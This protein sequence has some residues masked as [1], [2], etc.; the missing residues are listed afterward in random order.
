VLPVTAARSNTQLAWTALARHMGITRTARQRALIR[1]ALRDMEW[2][3][4]V[5]AVLDRLDGRSEAASTILAAANSDPSE[6][7]QMVGIT[8]LSDRGQLIGLQYAS[9]YRS[10]LLDQGSEAVSVAGEVT[11]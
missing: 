9:G 4:D 1:A 8:P 6:P 10:Y 7:L 5:V 11:R 3:K 2:T